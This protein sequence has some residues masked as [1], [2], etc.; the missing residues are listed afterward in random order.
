MVKSSILK[1]IALIMGTILIF[2]A[3]TSLDCLASRK[4]NVKSTDNFKIQPIIVAIFPSGS[5]NK[6][7]LF[8]LKSN[9]TLE[10]SFG[11]RKNDNIYATQLYSTK[12]KKNKKL[13]AQ[14]LK[15]IVRIVNE[16][17]KMKD[18]RSRID[19]FDSWSVNILIGKKVFNFN[20]NEHQEDNLGKLIQLIMKDSPI[21]V[22]F[23]AFA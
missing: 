7:Y 22:K 12:E 6:T 13:T 16:I 1:I 8:K 11:D 15:Q 10:A 23:R 5:Y 14:E 20:I 17:K 9:G 21:K 18:I 4:I 2:T 3:S 19:G